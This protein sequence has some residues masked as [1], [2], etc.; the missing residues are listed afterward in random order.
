[1]LR[2]KTGKILRRIY[3]VRDEFVGSSS[4]RCALDEARRAFGDERVCFLITLF[5]FWCVPRICFGE[6]ISAP[7]RAFVGRRRATPAMNVAQASSC[8]KGAAEHSR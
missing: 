4:R 3:G 5:L 1:M 6:F 7:L 2:L 8:E